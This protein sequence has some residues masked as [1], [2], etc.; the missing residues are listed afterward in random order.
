MLFMAMLAGEVRRPPVVDVY[1]DEPW[2]SIEA[3]AGDRRDRNAPLSSRTTIT[4]D[5]R[6]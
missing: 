2:R 1:D 3:T 6:R 4:S 5:K